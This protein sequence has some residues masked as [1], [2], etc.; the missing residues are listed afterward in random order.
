MSA[1]KANR[2]NSIWLSRALLFIAM[3]FLVMSLPMLFRLVDRIRFEQSAKT[4]ATLYAEQVRQKEQLVTTLKARQEYARTD[5]FVEYYARVQ[6]RLARPGETLVI[7]VYP[8]G[9]PKPPV[10]MWPD[11]G[12]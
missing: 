6:M 8:D 4:Q 1:S 3:L 11:S 9:Q 2:Q 10:S 7:P 12:N 5:A